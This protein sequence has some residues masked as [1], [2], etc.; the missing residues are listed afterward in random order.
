MRVA[1]QGSFRP[2]E[3]RHSAVFSLEVR[4]LEA[5]AEADAQGRY[6]LFN[7]GWRDP[8]GLASRLAHPGASNFETAIARLPSKL[9]RAAEDAFGWSLRA[10]ELRRRGV[11]LLHVFEH[12]Y[13][14][15][16]RFPSLVT[17]YDCIPK[18]R[19]QWGDASVRRAMD[20]NAARAKHLI[21]VSE[22]TKQDLL[23]V[24][25]LPDDRV[26]VVPLGIDRRAFRPRPPAETDALRARLKL[27]ERFALTFGQ[28]PRKNVEAVLEAY[29]AWT[30]RDAD[31]GLVV[32]GTRNVYGERL[33]ALAR[34]RGLPRVLFPGEVSDDEL[35]GLYSLAEVLVYA[36]RYEG[37]GMPPLEAMACGC[38]V[39]ASNASGIPEGVGDAGVLFDPESPAD[40]RDRV[41]ELLDSRDR[42]RDLSVKGTARAA[43][44]TW[45]RNA[46]AT[47]ALYRKLSGA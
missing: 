15:P 27:P 22:W 3:G 25:G 43:A 21:A 38:P 19:P 2:S 1:I 5:L 24:Y 39:A 18:V 16:P 14:A 31:L 30:A 36:S 45:E 42:R 10:R 40:L 44:F 47:L 20:L 29:P 41:A 37:M 8:A 4:F 46:R 28:S 13:P 33:Q 6:L 35:A 9:V 23:R 17:F 11:T 26:T 32:V 7:V 12:I 34:E